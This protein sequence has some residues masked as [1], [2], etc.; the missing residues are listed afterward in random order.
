M[1]QIRLTSTAQI[2]NNQR[3]KK[4]HAIG[5]ISF[6]IDVF[7]NLY[8]RSDDICLNSNTTKT[9]GFLSA[10]VFLTLSLIE[11]LF[12]FGYTFFQTT[13]S[14][15]MSFKPVVLCFSKLIISSSSLPAITT[16]RASVFCP[17]LNASM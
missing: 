16:R 14:K 10:T 8:I 1:I 3:I 5:S 2:R 4:N 13:P 11:N 7:S 15:L 9:K 12:N 17:F 6:P